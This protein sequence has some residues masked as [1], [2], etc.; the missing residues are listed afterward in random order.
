[1]KTSLE[2][3]QEAELI[4]IYQIAERSGLEP[5]QAE[6]AVRA[7]RNTLAQRHSGGEP[8]DLAARGT[9]ADCLLLNDQFATHKGAYQS[10]E[11]PVA[12][13]AAREV[14][15]LPIFPELTEDEVECVAQTVRSFFSDF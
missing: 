6:R 4:P 13:Q 5:D 2:I 3:A 9:H 15:A 11:F 1:M 12:E 7:T 10:D 14:L 8:F